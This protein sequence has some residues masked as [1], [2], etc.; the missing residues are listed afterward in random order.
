VKARIQESVDALNARQASYA[1]IKRFAILE[2]DFS[3]EQG[4]LTP[5]L[6]VK[7]KVVTERHRK[8]LDSLYVE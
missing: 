5:T 6:K 3:Q 2:T 4:D 7:R 8:L 1:T